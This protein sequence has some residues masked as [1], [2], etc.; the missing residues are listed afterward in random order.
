[1]SNKVTRKKHVDMRKFTRDASRLTIDE[2]AA[3][4]EG[5]AATTAPADTGTLRNSIGR[6]V[7]RDDLAEVFSDVEYAVYQEFGTRFMQAQPFMRPA[8]DGLRS[9]L[10]RVWS[11]A[12]GESY[13]RNKR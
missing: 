11:K 12:T 4:V 2:A 9:D 7:L 5:N 6:R 3:V 10:N 13:A 8:L 1:V